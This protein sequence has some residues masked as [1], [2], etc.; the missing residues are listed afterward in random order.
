MTTFPQGCGDIIKGSFNECGEDG[1]L[2][3]SC[4]APVDSAIVATIVRCLP[5]DRFHRIARAADSARN[6]HDL[7]QAIIANPFLLLID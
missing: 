6:D 5:H 1:C 3:A 4:N 7:K 2:C